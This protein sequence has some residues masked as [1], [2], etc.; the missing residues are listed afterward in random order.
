M[1]DATELPSGRVVDDAA[2]EGV[3]GLHRGEHTPRV[4]A[5]AHQLPLRQG[6]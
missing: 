6:A 1:G 4:P 3:R 2:R 5:L